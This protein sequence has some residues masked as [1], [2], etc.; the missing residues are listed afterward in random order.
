MSYLLTQMLVCL[1]IAGLIGGVI[2]WFLKGNCSGKLKKCEEK[3]ENIND[4]DLSKKSHSLNQIESDLEDKTNKEH[5]KS[6]ESLKFASTIPSEK[7]V[8]KKIV[9]NEIKEGIKIEEEVLDE[10]RLEPK[11]TFIVDRRNCYPL[12]NIEGI[13]QNNIKK[14]NKIGIE[15]SCDL[16]ENFYKNDKAVSSAAK[17]MKVKSEIIKSWT[18]MADLLRVPGIGAIQA[19]LLYSINIK[20][21]SQLSNSNVKSLQKS[22]SDFNKKTKVL[23][24]LPSEK[25]LSSWIKLSKNL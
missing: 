24:D 10:P 13:T 19:E 8:D 3:Y 18:S 16:I 9:D 5:Q 21:V 12:T 15:N 17:T 2:G 6:Q 14:L 20:S 23:G 1:L 4:Y 22:I 25:S 11:R 7:I